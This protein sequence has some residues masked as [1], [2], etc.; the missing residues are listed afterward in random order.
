M[1]L[2]SP[3]THAYRALPERPSLEQ[4]R[5]QAKELH[6]AHARGELAEAGA[7]RR[8]QRLSALDDAALARTSLTLSDAQFALA[9][10][11]GLPSWVELKQKVAL[12]RGERT[13][14]TV[15]RSGTRVAITGL[16]ALGPMTSGRSSYADALSAALSVTEQPVS[17]DQVMAYSGLAFRAR[18]FRGEQENAW[19]C[20]TSAL[21]EF[22]PE[23]EAVSA[24][25]GWLQRH[26]MWQ[27]GS[28]NVHDVLPAIT[29]SLDRGVPVVGYPSN[30]HMDLSVLFAYEREGDQL[31]LRWLDYKHEREL[32]LPAEKLGFLVILLERQG[33]V[34]D[35]RRALLSALGSDNWRCRQRPVPRRDGAYY[36]GT[37]AYDTW[38]RDLE[39]AADYP[40]PM[41]RQLCFVSWFCFAALVDARSAAATFLNQTA[42]DFEDEIAEALRTA[43][44]HYAAACGAMLP[45]VNEQLAFRPPSGEPGFGGWDDAT[46]T[47]ERAILQQVRS[48]D[49]AAERVLDGLMALPG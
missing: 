16:P 1:S 35:G 4:L 3:T 41:R 48:H 5:K 21:G 42:D 17:Y 7:L 22:P 38:S 23:M 19:F 40:E 15:E 2:T 28:R 12:L 26:D 20:P 33:L 10:D 36:Y 25:T 32:V 39:R 45:A 43:A 44:G 18:W 6:R 27:G 47:Q 46:R 11:Y 30:E 31:T 13:L 29:A 49:A 24:A 37:L 34:P 8:I 14:G 9:L